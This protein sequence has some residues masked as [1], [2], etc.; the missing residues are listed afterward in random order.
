MESLEIK[1]NNLQT[2][3]CNLHIE[4]CKLQLELQSLKNTKSHPFKPMYGTTKNNNPS[5]GVK[6]W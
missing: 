3:M 2:Q 1:I 4:M 6:P 5:G